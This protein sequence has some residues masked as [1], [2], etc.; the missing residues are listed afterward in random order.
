MD[1]VTRR[2]RFDDLKRTA[3]SATLSRFKQHLA[4]LAWLDS[5]GS[6]AGWVADVPPAKVPHFAAQARVTDAG[7][8]RDIGEEKK[9]VLIA[10]LLHT[11][12]IRGR[13]ELATM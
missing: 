1:P 13:D 3:G 5:L 11:A 6:T 9:V 4:H 8:M 10:A 12:R 7:D 2:S